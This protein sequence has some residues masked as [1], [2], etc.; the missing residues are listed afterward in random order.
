[1]GGRPKP[2]GIANRYIPQQLLGKRE[3]EGEIER[4]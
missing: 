2:I 1:V 3:E 4:I